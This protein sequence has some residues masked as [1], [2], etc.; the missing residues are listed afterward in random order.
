[1]IKYWEYEPKKVVKRRKL[2]KSTRRIKEAIA[3]KTFFKENTMKKRKTTEV[4]IK[5]P[6]KTNGKKVKGMKLKI[7]KSTNSKLKKLKL[8]AE[9][10]AIP[11]SERAIAD[12]IK[13]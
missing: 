3:P 12:L 7:S 11:E 5:N 6:F 4:K 13:G 1:M 2:K 10:E 8:I 9:R